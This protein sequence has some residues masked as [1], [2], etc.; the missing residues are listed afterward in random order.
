[1]APV[2]VRSYNI[3]Y[4]AILCFAI[5]TK[6]NAS[7]QRNGQWKQPILSKIVTFVEN[8]LENKS[9]QM[10]CCLTLCILTKVH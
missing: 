8:Y 10:K 4:S 6:C 3:V 7:G 9:I 1:M 5:F 2:V